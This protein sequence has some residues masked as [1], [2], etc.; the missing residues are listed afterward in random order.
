MQAY[1]KSQDKLLISRT[2]TKLYY[3]RHDEVEI[4]TK[5]ITPSM[6][7]KNMAV[8]KCKKRE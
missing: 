5:H 2:M 4:L 8:L 3:H 6:D 1:T 7:H